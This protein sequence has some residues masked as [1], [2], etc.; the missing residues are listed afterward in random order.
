MTK[1]EI[2]ENLKNNRDDFEEYFKTNPHDFDE[3]LKRYRAILGRIK[4]LEND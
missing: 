4:E 1:E 2:L 3:C